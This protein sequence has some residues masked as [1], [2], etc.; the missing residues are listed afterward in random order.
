MLDEGKRIYGIIKTAKNFI[1]IW[2]RLMQTS[3]TY[4]INKLWLTFLYINFCVCF[5]F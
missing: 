4:I 2:L 5:H 3:N 1:F